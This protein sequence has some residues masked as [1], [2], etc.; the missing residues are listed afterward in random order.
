[1]QN[2]ETHF[3]PTIPSFDPKPLARV[4][5][6]TTLQHL[7]ERVQQLSEIARILQ[8]TV[9]QELMQHLQVIN[10]QSDQLILAIDHANWGFTIRYE[11]ES[12]LKALHHYPKY[13]MLKKIRC[14][15]QLLNTCVEAARIAP[16]RDPISKTSANILQAAAENIQDPELKNSL[17]RLAAQQPSHSK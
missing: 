8:K 13:R 10:I 6:E 11:E 12:I 5:E 2:M 9:P 1:M 3:N 16:P 14:R 4:F 17:L 7:F 15:I